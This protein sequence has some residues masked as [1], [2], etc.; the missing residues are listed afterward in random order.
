MYYFHSLTA[1]YS[2]DREQSIIQLQIMKR[3]QLLSI[4]L[5]SCFVCGNADFGL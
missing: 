5:G 4:L 1:Q 2:I 3:I